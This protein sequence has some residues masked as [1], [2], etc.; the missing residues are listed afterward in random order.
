MSC[1]ALAAEAV[2]AGFER[3]DDSLVFAIRT[4]SSHSSVRCAL[5]RCKYSRE[6]ESAS[7][8]IKWSTAKDNR[9][10]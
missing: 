5:L 4:V 3:R 1:A 10:G 2:R 6:D 8:E 7:P 9:F